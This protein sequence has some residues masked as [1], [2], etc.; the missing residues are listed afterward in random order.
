MRETRLRDLANF[1]RAPPTA[2]FL[3]QSVK[4]FFEMKMRGEENSWRVDCGGNG[5]RVPFSYYVFHV[6]RHFFL[7]LFGPEIFFAAS[8]GADLFK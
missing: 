2:P 6:M 4:H 7:K 5:W 1:G 3:E 8:G